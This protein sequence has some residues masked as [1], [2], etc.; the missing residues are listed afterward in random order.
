MQQQKKGE[1]KAANENLKL[2]SKFFCVDFPPSHEF[3]TKRTTP[4]FN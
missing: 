3:F 4:D 2:F 1:K